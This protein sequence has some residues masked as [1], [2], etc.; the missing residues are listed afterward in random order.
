MSNHKKQRT[1]PTHPRQGN[2]HVPKLPPAPAP[3]KIQGRVAKSA[4]N[5]FGCLAQGLK[6]G[7]VKGTD[8]IKFIHKDQVPAERI[9]DVTY[10]SFRCDYKPNKEEKEHT[11]LTT[12]GDRINYPDD[13]RTPT[14]DMTL[15]KILINSIL[16]TPNAKC[17]MMDIKDFYLRTPM[18]RPEYMQLK[19]TD[20]PEEI[21]EQYKLKSSATPDGYIYCE[22]TRGMYGL[23]QAAIIAQEL[24]EKQLAEYGYYQS[25]IINRSWKHKTRPIC[26][27]L[28]VDDFA[29]KYVNREDANHLINTIRKYFPMTVDEE[30]TKYIGLTIEW[31]YKK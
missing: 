26:F 5:E 28:V 7:R 6:D 19:I 18:K 27:C 10:G 16:S 1:S 20:I 25:K 24:L 11:R 13:C 4:A 29:V 2:E 22:I 12:G 31:E 9:K 3:P 30:A 8:T 21:I 23:P 14:A 17:I 15:F